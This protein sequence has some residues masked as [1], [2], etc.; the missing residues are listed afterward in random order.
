MTKNKE[1]LTERQQMVEQLLDQ[2]DFHG[3]SQ[4]VIFGQDGVLKDLT[5]RIV[6][7]T[8]NVEMDHHLGYE[9]NSSLGDNS[10]NSRNGSSK[11]TIIASGQPGS[12]D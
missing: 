1:P 4:D 9:K 3:L 2:I 8:L 11:K 5:K 12:R 6:E 10:G 7:R